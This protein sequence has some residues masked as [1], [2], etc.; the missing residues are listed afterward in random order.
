MQP[1]LSQIIDPCFYFPER[2]GDFSCWKYP[3]ELQ[4]LHLKTSYHLNR[5]FGQKFTRNAK[6][7]F[8]C[9]KLIWSGTFEI[10]NTEPLWFW[11]SIGSRVKIS[12]YIQPSNVSSTLQFLFLLENPSQ[13]FW[14]NEPSHL[15]VLQLYILLVTIRKWHWTWGGERG[16][17]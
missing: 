11:S 17:N 15:S 14:R 5:V 10:F 4:L 13:W 7:G 12:H 3:Q 9:L 2:F 1:I 8:E 16:C 6:N